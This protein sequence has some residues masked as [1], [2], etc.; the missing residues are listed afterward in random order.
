MTRYAL[1]IACVLAFGGALVVL[2]WKFTGQLPSGAGVA[3][4]ALGVFFL[5]GLQLLTIGILGEYIS[6]I[7]RGQDARAPALQLLL[8]HAS[9][10]R[11]DI[12]RPAEMFA[13][14]AKAD[15]QTVM[16]ADL[17]VETAHE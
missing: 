11:G 10:R 4:I 1:G 8:R 5:G 7:F 9:E 6:R 17:V 13:R 2:A 14:M 15:A 3:T 16:R 12:Q